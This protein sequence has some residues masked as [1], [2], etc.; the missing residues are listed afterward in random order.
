MA[1]SGLVWLK[2]KTCNSSKVFISPRHREAQ[3]KETQNSVPLKEETIFV[4]Q[5]SQFGINYFTTS[6]FGQT[7]CYF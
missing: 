7:V 2:N 5:I 1:L 4:A 6:F 3:Q